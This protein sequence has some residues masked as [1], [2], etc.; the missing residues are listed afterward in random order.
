[1][2]RTWA[3]CQ[4]SGGGLGVTGAPQTVTDDRG[5]SVTPNAILVRSPASVKTDKGLTFSTSGAAWQYT[6][7]P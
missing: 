1:M 2:T 7:V 6:D 3:G 5:Q 4:A